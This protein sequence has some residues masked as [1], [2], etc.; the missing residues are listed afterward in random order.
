MRTKVA[1]PHSSSK[2]MRKGIVAG[3]AGIALLAGGGA[4]FATW[5]DT[6]KAS[7]TVKTGTLSLDRV[8]KT[9]PQWTSDGTQVQNMKDFRLT[10]G[11]AVTYTDRIVL[12][13]QGAEITVDLAPELGKFAEMD[14]VRYSVKVRE[15]NVSDNTIFEW[16]DKGDS[17]AA[18]TTVAA[19]A[20]RTLELL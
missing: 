11:T 3:V 17:T 6:Y 8:S 15:P 7:A 20:P 19:G 16:N 2:K 18:H 4:S 10:P 1:Q 12:T 14:G 13:A 5:S 9:A